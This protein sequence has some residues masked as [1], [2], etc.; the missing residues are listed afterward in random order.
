MFLGLDLIGD[1]VDI[2]DQADLLLNKCDKR[3]RIQ[4]TKLIKKWSRSFLGSTDDI[5]LGT[6]SILGELLQSSLANTTS[7]TDEEGDQGSVGSL[8]VLI[9]D[10][11][12]LDAD[13]DFA[14][15]CLKF[16]SVVVL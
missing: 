1:L 13:H 3:L 14:D 9:G 8:E 10:T 15:D 4:T 2:L 6:D 5:D 11:N 7:G 12:V 16:G